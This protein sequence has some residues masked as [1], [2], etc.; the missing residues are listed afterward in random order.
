VQYQLK[1]I[2]IDKD[3]AKVLT[4]A[5]GKLGS[6]NVMNSTTST[7]LDATRFLAAGFV[8]LHHLNDWSGKALPIFA[9]MQSQAV[10][11]FFV[12][13]GF[14]IAYVADT[15][16]K[17][18]ADYA[19]SR[20]ARIYSVALPALIATFILDAFA[21]SSMPD[22]HQ[23][24]DGPSLVTQFAAG[25]FFLNEVW[26]HHI[27]IGSNNPYWSLGYE[28]P[29]YIA[30]AGYT[31]S[32]G[33]WRYL[34]PAL[35]LA[36]YGPRVAMLAP[37]WLMGV[38]SYRICAKRLIAPRFGWVLLSSSTVLW[39]AFYAGIYH[40]AVPSSI[41]PLYWHHWEIAEDV[42]VAILFSLNVIGF[43]AVSKSFA[44]LAQR[45]QGIVRWVAGTTFTLYLFHYPIVHCLTAVLHWQIEGAGD[46][47]LLSLAVVLSTFAL[48]EVTER[49]KN[50][51][52]YLFGLV[53]QTN[54]SRSRA[55][56]G[57]SVGA[58]STPQ[59]SKGGYPDV[60]AVAKRE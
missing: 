28:V 60:Q 55:S 36:A 43:D 21:S 24:V 48:A 3:T 26:S 53:I 35:V 41:V 32:R 52:R 16:E 7:Y 37:I 9:P 8:F 13:S 34:L 4:P 11:I 38:A 33:H 23:A 49:R 50:F 44:P 1:K 46:M 12:L 5:L 10:I 19:L 2:G 30:F 20:L 51:Y 18:L 17:Q 42:F 47:I 29:Y 40:G 45:C 57:R 27:A 54:W 39:M 56:E 15:K 31:F 25:L 59:Y 6:T 58:T 22:V 14:V